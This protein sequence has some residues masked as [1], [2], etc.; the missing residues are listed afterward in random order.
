MREAADGM[1]QWDAT[2]GERKHRACE[3]EGGMDWDKNERDQAG[4][5]PMGL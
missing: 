4:G 5:E 2:V 3:D 1:A